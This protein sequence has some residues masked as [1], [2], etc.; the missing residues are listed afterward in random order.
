[1]AI[2]HIKG[3]CA[4]IYLLQLHFISINYSVMSI[5]L[6]FSSKN[7]TR[8]TAVKIVLSKTINILLKIVFMLFL[9]LII[10]YNWTIVFAL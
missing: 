7:F 2:T 1:M 6:K 10:T 8:P 4:L 9:Y 3:K 5:R